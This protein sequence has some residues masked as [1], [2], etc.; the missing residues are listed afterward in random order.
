MKKT[1]ISLAV[2][3]S[4]YANAQSSTVCELVT[5][6]YDFGVKVAGEMVS[7]D[8]PVEFRCS[9]ND[10]SFNVFSMEPSKFY[11]HTEL[12]SFMNG[13]RGSLLDEPNAITINGASGQLRGDGWYYYNAQ[14]S[15]DWLGHGASEGYVNG[16]DLG[17]A[18]S[19]R[20]DYIVSTQNQRTPFFI[21]FS[22]NINPSCKDMD[23]GY[24]TLNFGIVPTGLETYS[25]DM[26][27]KITCTKDVSEVRIYPA[28]IDVYEYVEGLGFRFMTVGEGRRHITQANPYKYNPSIG[29][30]AVSLEMFNPRGERISRGS[31][32][33]FM[34]S[35][36][37]EY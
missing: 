21:D 32:F 34:Y 3:F 33:N 20:L 27:L 16:F 26:E 28:F 5:N 8:I 23:Y 31:D 10:T 37:I 15:V 24:K 12:K 19:G 13:N 25:K 35:L 1:I 18:Y 7:A 17:G 22:V 6:M 30:G 36:M 14:F 11:G 29:Y 9:G 4:S 2:L